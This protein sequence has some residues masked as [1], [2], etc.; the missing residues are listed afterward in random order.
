MGEGDPYFLA[1]I[2]GALGDKAQALAYLNQAIDYHSEYITNPDY[3]GLRT[4]PAWDDLR[5]DPRFDALCRR[6]WMGKG[7]WPK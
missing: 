7:Q 2:H 4:D 1:W 3:G 6:V 5:D